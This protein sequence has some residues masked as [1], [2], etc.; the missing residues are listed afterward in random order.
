MNGQ[1]RGDCIK[2]ES[3]LA[4]NQV[5]S[6]SKK[7]FLNKEVQNGIVKYTSQPNKLFLASRGT[8]SSH[9][10]VILICQFSFSTGGF[11]G[12]TSG[13]SRIYSLSLSEGH[14][15]EW[16]C[17]QGIVILS[18]RMITMRGPYFTLRNFLMGG[19]SH[20]WNIW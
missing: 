1:Q 2:N 11:S 19:G 4:P 12:Q 20:L 15:K 6:R 5:P 7:Q 10:A 17:L 16:C 14:W 9:G 13:L 8:F 3:F 18:A